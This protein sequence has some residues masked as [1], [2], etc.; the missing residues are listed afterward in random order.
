MPNDNT[1]A[2]DIGII[3]GGPAG[4]C[5]AIFASVYAVYLSSFLNQK[6]DTIDKACGEGLMPSVVQEFKEMGVVIPESHPFKGIR[7]INQQGAHKEDPNTW[8]DG[9]FQSGDGWGVRRLTL[10]N[11]L[12]Q[13]RKNLELFGNKLVFK[14]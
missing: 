13:E 10:H 12:T 4:L 14:T 2:Y 1:H 6:T 8:A 3:G 11:A 7:Y 5:A 9:H